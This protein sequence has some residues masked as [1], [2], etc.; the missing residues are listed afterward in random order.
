MLL[1]R[2]LTTNTGGAHSENS[3]LQSFIRKHYMHIKK[4][5]LMIDEASFPCKI[6]KNRRKADIHYAAA[7]LQVMGMHFHCELSVAR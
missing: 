7:T 5:V 1:P 6:G 3:H 4:K 2:I